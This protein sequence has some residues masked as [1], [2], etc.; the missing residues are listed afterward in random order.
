MPREKNSCVVPHKNRRPIEPRFIYFVSNL[1][2][3]ISVLTLTV[4]RYVI[5][6]KLEILLLEFGITLF[7]IQQ[8]HPEILQLLTG[9]GN[10]HNYT[11]EET[12]EY[13]MS[14]SLSRILILSSFHRNLNFNL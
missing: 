13:I 11:G 4:I 14:Q 3:H 1:C 12:E 2:L 6:L 10:L 8:W 7:P 5:W 9:L